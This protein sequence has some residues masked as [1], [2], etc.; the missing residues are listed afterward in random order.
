MA[1]GGSRRFL[2]GKSGPRW[3]FGGKYYRQK[4]G[5]KRP[6]CG[7]CRPK[8]VK[9]GKNQ[10]SVVKSGAKAPFFCEKTCKKQCG[11]NVNNR[12]AANFSLDF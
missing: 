5:Q 8:A 9:F 10:K 4:E 1:A 7:R 2:C 12:R 3:H 11:I 6:F